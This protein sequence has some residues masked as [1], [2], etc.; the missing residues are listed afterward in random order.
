MALGSD[1]G[2]VGPFTDSL[3]TDRALIWNNMVT[4]LKVLDVQT[5]LNPTKKHCDGIMGYK[6]IYNH[7][8][9]PSNIYHVV[10][11]AEKKLDNCTYTG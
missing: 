6:L 5:Y 2:V 9:D 7:C 3:V 1:P 10:S 4:I 8:M 11:G